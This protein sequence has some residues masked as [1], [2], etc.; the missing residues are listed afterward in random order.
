MVPFHLNENE[1]IVMNIKKNLRIINAKSGAREELPVRKNTG[2]TLIEIPFYTRII[3][4]NR[5]IVD[6]KVPG[7]TEKK[8]KIEKK[9]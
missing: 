8:A 7:S 1:Y 6:E 2:A 3:D 9:N 5:V 4:E